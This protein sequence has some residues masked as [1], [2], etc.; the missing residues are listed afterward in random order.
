[1]WNIRH[2]LRFGILVATLELPVLAGNVTLAW[3]PDLNPNVAG[4]NIYF[5]VKGGHSTNR[6]S[7]GPATC[8]TISNL[9]AGATCYFAAT[10]YDA[11]GLQ[12]PF[13][14]PLV[15][16]MPFPPKLSI[17]T[18]AINQQGINGALTA[19]GKASDNAAVSSV[20]YALN[21]SP[22]TAATTTNHWTNWSANLNLT[23]GTNLIQSY[24][25][26]ICANH[27]STNTVK[28]VYLV[29]QPL[30]VNLNGKG[31][32]NP[33]Y[34][35]ALLAVNVNYAISANARSGFAFTNWTDAAGN[36]LTNRATLRFTMQTNLALTANFVDVQKP[37]LSI[38]TPR[39]NQQT[40]NAGF[41][42]TGRAADNVSV[43]AVYYS[44]NDSAWTL[45]GTA[46]GWTNWAANLTLA[47]GFNT[48][49]VFAADNHG[50]VSSTNAVKMEYLVRQ[51]LTVF[52]TGKGSVSPNYNKSALAINENYAMTAKASSGFAFTNWTD[53]FGNTLTNR[54]TL[55]FT[56]QTNLTL[57]AKF[58]DISRPT[59][60][61]TAPAGKLRVSNTMFTVTGKASDNVA[62]GTVWYSFNGSVW[63]AAT[64]GN[65]WTNWL[66]AVMLEPGT[67]TIRVCAVDTSGNISPTNSD[68]VNLVV[69]PTALATLGSAAYGDSQYAFLVS[70]ATGY[71]YLVQA[72]TDLVN[73]VSLETNTAP[74]TFV[75]TNASQFDERFYRTIFNP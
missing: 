47:P 6:V 28:F 11:F 61:L 70:G 65:H 50:N 60:S 24:A 35:G 3:N 33:N 64:T 19:S 20:F 45:A 23:P 46:N 75:D 16:T 31:S 5:W 32:V 25:V 38:S 67:N 7:I 63:T 51:P 57:I 21:G 71:K 18:P 55:K 68:M 44:L 34:N 62:V 27:S 30:T 48:L 52:I 58:A 49:Q 40:T 69:P 22:W 17:V 54:A 42:T 43:A 59:L 41:T 2:F 74:F 56:M 29:R 66:A 13:S 36:V 14:S 10:T 26:D 39:A 37:A 8:V 72:S 12:S 15:F 4:Y 1:M 53:G 9:V 73:W